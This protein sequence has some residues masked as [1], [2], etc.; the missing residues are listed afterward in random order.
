MRQAKRRILR[1]A[2]MGVFEDAKAALK[3]LQE[4]FDILTKEAFEEQKKLIIKYNAEEQ[5]YKLG[6]D[7]KKSLIRPAYQKTTI[8]IK[9]AKGQPTNRVTLRDTGKFHK[10]LK[11]IPFDDYVEI[12]SDLEYSKYLLKKYGDDI[13]GIQDELLKD[14]V[15]LYVVPKIEEEAKKK[16]EL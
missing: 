3:D 5:M 7:S 16:L 12:R 10:T 15:R 2:L 13:L 8:R 14:F 9:K 4:S 11:V 1:D 6:Q